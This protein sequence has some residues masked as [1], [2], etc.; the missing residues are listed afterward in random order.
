ML[1][2]L[3]SVLLPVRWN[4]STNPQNTQGL[5]NAPAFPE[6]SLLA[7]TEGNCCWVRNC[8]KIR[9]EAAKGKCNCRHNTEVTGSASECALLEGSILSFVL[10]NL[11]RK[12]NLFAV[13]SFIFPQVQYTN[14]TSL[15]WNVYLL[16]VSKVH[17]SLKF[18]LCIFFFH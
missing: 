13:R 12:R 18:S 15:H 2:V 11:A 4:K 6:H 8:W 5:W 10:S 17:I 3:S 7:C 9:E 14:N 16:S 1:S